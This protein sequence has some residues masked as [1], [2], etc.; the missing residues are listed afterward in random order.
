MTETTAT[1]TTDTTARSGPT[2][3]MLMAVSVI[4]FVAY[5]VLMTATGGAS[6]VVALPLLA[7]GVGAIVWAARSDD[8]AEAQA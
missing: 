6:N 7:I 5:S 1:D 2:A 3:T 8:V 4:A